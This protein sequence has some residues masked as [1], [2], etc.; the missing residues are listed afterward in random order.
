MISPSTPTAR[1]TRCAAAAF[2]ARRAPGG[3]RG[4]LGAGDLPIRA[5]RSGSQEKHD[6]S[7]DEHEL[8]D[9]EGGG[10]ESDH[11]VKVGQPR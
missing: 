8:A 1:I 10:H 3:E 11:D 4:Q 6:D 9:P 7:G 2:L 5:A